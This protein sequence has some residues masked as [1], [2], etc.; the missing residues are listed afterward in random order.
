MS[1]IIAK[2]PA[3][4]RW[5]PVPGAA[6][7]EVSDAGQVRS[8]LARGFGRAP[9][10]PRLL[11][12]QI[13]PDGY[14]RVHL[15]CGGHRVCRKV[16]ALV[17]S[18]F[19]GERPAGHDACHNNGVR[20]DDRLENLRWASRKDNLADRQVH[21]TVNNGERNGAAVLNT[22]QVRAIRAD[23]AS[24]SDIAEKF[25]IGQATVSKIKRGAR[26]AHVQ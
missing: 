13:A 16:A 14:F 3:A 25:G 9:A 18:A 21:G 23:T 19:A 5:L 2:S 6:G 8:C 15:H 12:P 11:R 1:R 7:Y 22:G 4:A 10:A 17:L 20:T 24:Q 26:W